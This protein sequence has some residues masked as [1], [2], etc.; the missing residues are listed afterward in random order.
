[1]ISFGNEASSHSGLTPLETAYK[2][3]GNCSGRSR[4]R[5]ILL[6][7]IQLLLIQFLDVIWSVPKNFAF[8][9]KPLAKFFYKFDNPE[10]NRQEVF[11]LLLHAVMLTPQQ[12]VGLLADI[13]DCTTY[14]LYLASD[15]TFNFWRTQ[16]LKVKCSL[17]TSSSCD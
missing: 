9:Q 3:E 2:K 14:L 10:I 15:V 4:G 6:T 8:F 11:P 7:C 16:T 12:R 17:Y 1:M 5:R 13:L